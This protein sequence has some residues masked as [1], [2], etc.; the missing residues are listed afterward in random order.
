MDVNGVVL[1]V[2]SSFMITGELHPPP[3]RCLKASRMW[4]T[5][6][7]YQVTD[8]KT[9]AEGKAYVYTINAGSL[10]HPEFGSP[11]HGDG[12]T[13]YHGGKPGVHI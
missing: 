11:K 6:L 1:T 8:S 3:I 9:T 4:T 12:V 13:T 10:A 5:H 7:T 2:D